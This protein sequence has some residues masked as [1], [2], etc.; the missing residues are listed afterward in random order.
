MRDDG[1][2]DVDGDNASE[3]ALSA[4]PNSDSYRSPRFEG[5]LNLG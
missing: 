5:Q 1:D 3:G 4:A 2:A